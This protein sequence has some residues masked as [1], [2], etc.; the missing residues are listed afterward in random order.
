MNP[1]QSPPQYHL[2]S[3]LFESLVWRQETQRSNFP[4][5]PYATSLCTSDL[6]CS[7]D[8]IAS[9]RANFKKVIGEA[10]ARKARAQVNNDVRKNKL[11]EAHM[12]R[13]NISGAAAGEPEAAVPPTA[14]SSISTTTGPALKGADGANL[15]SY[16]SGTCLGRV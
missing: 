11:M 12:K 16:V 13:R 1:P 8:G 2:K 6:R 14:P 9:R 5:K 15:A 7:M 3:I 10:E 4:H